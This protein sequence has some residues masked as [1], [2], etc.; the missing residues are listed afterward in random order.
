MAL[1]G[2]FEVSYKTNIDGIDIEERITMTH[3]TT[4]SKP[5][6]K[7]QEKSNSTKFSEILTNAKPSIATSRPESLGGRSPKG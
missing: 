3:G 5:R 6:F 1:H 7:L 2:N 4:I